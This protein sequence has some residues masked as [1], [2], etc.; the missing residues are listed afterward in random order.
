MDDIHEDKEGNLWI[1]KNRNKTDVEFITPVLPI[2]L[3]LIKKYE[4]HPKRIIN[5]LVLPV[6]TNQRYNAYLKEIAT[7]AKIKKNLTTHLARHTFATTV[8]LDNGI[9]IEIVSKMLGHRDIK[10]TQIYA[11]V[12]QKAIFF[13]M[14]KLM[15]KNEYD[16][17]QNIENN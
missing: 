13:S 15:D 12:Q 10:T 6:I 11:Q 7:L 8:T 2:P 16:D 5:N 14:K 17:T 4:T 3:S 1:S 9:P